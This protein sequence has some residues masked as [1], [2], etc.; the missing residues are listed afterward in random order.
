VYDQN[1]NQYVIKQ[2]DASPLSETFIQGIQLG[3]ILWELLKDCSLTNFIND[4]LQDCSHNALQPLN[5]DNDKEDIWNW[6]IN[7]SVNGI[8]YYSIFY[9]FLLLSQ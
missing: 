5:V 6:F 8:N 2:A 9:S 3:W 1:T 7:E 4:D